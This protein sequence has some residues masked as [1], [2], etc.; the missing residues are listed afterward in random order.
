LT[1]YL[2]NA[3]LSPRKFTHATAG[4]EDARAQLEEIR[5]QLADNAMVTSEPHAR[6]GEIADGLDTT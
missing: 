2:A 5:R 6:L 4:T 1:G 3:L